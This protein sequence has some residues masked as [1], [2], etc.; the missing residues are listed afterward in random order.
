MMTPEEQARFN[1]EMLRLVGKTIC[2]CYYESRGRW[3]EHGP[4]LRV[5]RTAVTLTA[6]YGIPKTNADVVELVRKVCRA[7]GMS[8]LGNN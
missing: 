7:Q 4:S 5:I 3:P 6:D 8:P 1:F 2:C